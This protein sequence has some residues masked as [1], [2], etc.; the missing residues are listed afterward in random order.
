[1]TSFRLNAGGVVDRSQPLR[2]DWDG[3]TMSGLQ[4]DTLASALL[5]NGVRVVG[6]SFKYHRPRGV[7]TA[8]PEEGGALVTTGRGAQRVPNEKAPMV[9]LFDGLQAS[10]Q[11]AWPGVRFDIGEIND[12]F[13]RFFT[14]GF[15]YKTFMGPGRGTWAWMQFEKLIRRAAGMGTASREPDPDQYDIVHDFCDLLVVGAGPAGLAAARQAAEDGLDVMLV[16][17]DFALG[18]R[19]IG[20]TETVEGQPADQWLASAQSALGSVRVLTRA[21][22]FG[23]YDGSIVGIY[24]RLTDHLASPDPQMPRG[25]IRIV[26]PRRIVLTTGAI[27]RPVAFGANDRPRVMLAGAMETYVRRFGVAPGSRAVV[28]TCHDG[29]YSS[30]M[31][32][33]AA[34]ISTTLLDARMALP[35]ALADAARSA[36]IELMPGY[37]PVEARGHKGVRGLQ[38]GRLVDEGSLARSEREIA[39]DCVGVSGG[40]S[41]AVHLV[42]HRGHKPVWSPELACFLPATAPEGVALAGA[43]RGVWATDA[44]LADAR[45]AAADAVAGLRGKRRRKAAERPE[46]GGWE[47]PIQPLWEVRVDGVKL[48][49]FV[50]PQHDVTT[51]DVRQA[52]R[53][54]YASV[55][56]MKRYTTLGMATDQGKL[57]NVIGLALL[58]DSLG[59]SVPETG[60]TTFR[61]PY[62]PVP[63]G[64]LAGRA[65][66]THWQPER[67]TAMHDAQADD[68]AVFTDAGL[69]KRAWWHP[70]FPGEPLE[71]AYVREARA[72]RSTCGMVDVSTLGK[73]AVQG[74]DAAE[75]LDRVFVN[76]FAKLPVMKCRYGVNLRDDGIVMDDGVTWRLA[77]D[78]F[79]V[80]CTTANAA[81][82][83]AWFENLLAFRWPAL[84][85]HV[86]STTDQ[87]AGVAVAGPRARAAL[88]RVVASGDV[89]K[90]G[91]PFMGIV[92][93]RVRVTDGEIPAMIARI[94][95]SGELAFEVYT[96]SGYGPALWKALVP[97]VRAEDG[98]A[99]GM[100]ALGAL[101][102]EKGH[103]TG[104]ELDG[105]TTLDDCGLGRMASTKKPFIGNAL[106][107]RPEL[108]RTDRPQLAHFLPVTEGEK[109][110]IGAVVCRE[111]EVKGHGIGW[112]TGVT[113]APA[114][115]DGWLGIGFV[116]GGPAAWEGKTVVIADPIRGSE[117]RARVASPHQFD[118]KGERMHA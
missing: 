92:H 49:S 108:S 50:D 69:W 5:A 118:P 53:E 47:T 2:F 65:R 95:F 100:E 114:L 59:Q 52:A 24:E 71:N 109:F 96:P 76:G 110:S 3:L 16:E 75:F 41:P 38:V 22:A 103:V 39:C 112:I 12:L 62:T 10:G 113:V 31:A 99:Y 7:M 74:P 80:T 90:D 15:Y 27:E 8:G 29:A 32:L 13:G 93:A 18:G 19:L 4:G 78:E 14:A 81:K 23:L 9:E 17:Q 57:G 66:G 35:P 34:G 101:R 98:C 11:N 43:A 104:A 82:M 67:R 107:H 20:S 68:G 1:M 89:S 55:E 42:S 84:R 51:D 79:L 87:W 117:V 46:P 60:I 48:K 116:T 86:A 45:T 33:A 115:G 30:A 70:A 102:I 97:S 56:H 44:V 40:W 64:A 83:M 77:E 21:T 105:R 25:A 106:R 26:R 6:R 37:V 88:E 61:P 111:G 58:A 72:V 94:S 85:V 28:A 63:I 54:G 73:I 91:L 36:G